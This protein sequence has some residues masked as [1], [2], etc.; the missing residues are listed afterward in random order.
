VSIIIL[1][2]YLVG[3]GSFDHIIAGST[4]MLYLVA[5]KTISFGTY[6]LHFFLPVLIG[7]VIG[8]FSLVAGLGHAQVV[9]GKK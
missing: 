8:G 3:L 9:G 1:I 4:T 7:N 2:T 5:T 6:F